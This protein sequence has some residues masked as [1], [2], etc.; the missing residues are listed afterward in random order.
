MV[1]CV[2]GQLRFNCLSYRNS[3][4]F[5][6]KLITVYNVRPLC[7]C[8]LRLSFIDGLVCDCFLSTDV[9]YSLSTVC[10]YLTM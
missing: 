3:L 1:D 10:H 7:F 5:I 6:R 8:L 2:H 9:F 4:T